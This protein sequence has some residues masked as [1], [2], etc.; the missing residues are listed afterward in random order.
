MY[1]CM[2]CMYIFMYVCM[3]LYNYV[4]HVCMYTVTDDL[5]VSRQVD[6]CAIVDLTFPNVVVE[7]HVSSASVR[8]QSG[9]ERARQSPQHAHRQGCLCEFTHA[10]VSILVMI[11]CIYV[12]M[13][14]CMYGVRI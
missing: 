8:Y 4:L 2:Y 5:A 1:V 10:N 11:F 3:Y 6:V 9:V 12:C 7:C 13:Y 14:V